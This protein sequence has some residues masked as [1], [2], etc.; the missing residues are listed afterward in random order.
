MSAAMTGFP[1]AMASSR[2]LARPSEVEVFNTTSTSP[3]AAAISC[4]AMAGSHRAKEASRL[5]SPAKRAPYSASRIGP[6]KT[7]RM[8]GRRRCTSSSAR[9]P[10][11][12]PLTGRIPAGRKKTN[13]SPPIPVRSRS[14]EG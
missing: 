4:G 1:A 11:R 13:S 7:A 12:L 5:I 8:P 10:A 9:S 6:E 2:V 3:Y 14:R